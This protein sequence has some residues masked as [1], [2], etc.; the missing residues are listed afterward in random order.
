MHFQKLLYPLSSFIKHRLFH[1]ILLSHLDI[2]PNLC[3]IIQIRDF[4]SL[5]NKLHFVSLLI[6]YI[7]TFKINILLL[8]P[9]KLYLIFSEL[10]KKPTTWKSPPK[11][12]NDSSSFGLLFLSIQFSHL[13]V[14][15]F[16]ELC[17]DLGWLQDSFD[18]LPTSLNP[19]N[20]SE[21]SVHTCIKY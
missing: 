2:L 17:P 7:Q 4:M 20:D 13:A 8:H 18:S 14:L 19:L 6:S 1:C 21:H 11:L 12:L 10:E 5:L 9:Q 15:L 16:D 3:M